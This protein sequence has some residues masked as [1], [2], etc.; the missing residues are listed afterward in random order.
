M[1][2]LQT[3]YI[4][5]GL[6]L[7]LLIY[8]AFQKPDWEET[9]KLAGFTFGG[10][11]LA[12]AVAGYRKLREGFRIRGRLLSFLLFLFLE[13]PFLVYAGT[14]FGL[15]LGAFTLEKTVDEEWLLPGCVGGGVVLGYGLWVLR[16]VQDRRVRLGASVFLAA[17]LGGGALFWFQ[18]QS[19]LSPDERFRFGVLVLLGTPVFYLLTFAGMAEESEVEFG[20]LCA[21]LFVGLWLV[22]ERLTDNPTGNSYIAAAAVAGLL[23]YLYTRYI[24]PGLRV[25]KHTLRGISYARIGQYRLA[26]VSLKRALHHDPNNALARETLW[27]VHREMDLGQVVQDPDTL[28]LVDFD[29]CLSRVGS[30]LLAGPKPEHLQEAHRLL[31]LV[32]GQ[33]PAMEPACDYW[34]AV[35]FC[36]AHEYERAAA[37]LERVLTPTPRNT[38]NKYRKEILMPAWQLALNLHPEMNRRVGTPQLALPQRRM[39]AIGAVERHLAANPDDPDAWNLKRV[40]YADLTE[41]EY[42]EAAGPDEPAKDFD[43]GYAQQLGLALINDPV[44]W[45]RGGEYLRMAA[46]GMPTLGPA[47]F[48]QIAKAH[49]RAG[50]VEGVWQNY[51]LVKLAGRSVGPKNLSAEDRQLYFAVVKLLADDAVSRGDL[52]AAIEDYLLYREYERSGKETYRTLAG[53]Y[54]QK[55]DVWAALHAT[56]QGLVYDG[57]DRDLLER[58]DR[59]YYSVTPDELRE[60]WESVYKYFDVSYC[61]SKAQSLLRLKEITL[62][63]LDWAQHLADLAQAAKPESLAAKVLRAR[64]RLLRG[65]REEAQAMLED[66]RVNRPEKFA[67]AEDEEAWYN[68]CKLLGNMYLQE[69][70]KPDLAVQ[71]FLDFRK[72]PKSGADTMFRLGQAYEELG[73]RVRA[74]KCYGQVVAFEDHPLAPDA[75]DALAR[76]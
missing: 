13:N 52:D 12:M 71:C 4:L 46:R 30:L 32:A 24:L 57:S 33:R 26:L 45:P 56:E 73:D 16:H 27:S 39:E 1:R 58:K 66:V 60:R 29:M 49:E 63:L 54:E 22:L 28:A 20:A 70:H 55:K 21:A 19:G 5:K 61:L 74:K 69:L 68:A 36:H 51:R 50:N 23:Y 40:L 65:E 25:F 34:R 48:I 41:A 47:L 42:D 18:T 15:A 31:D 10:L 38:T 43:H 11:A 3:E 64:T 76:L 35:A 9:A 59:Y 37:A 67:S 8:A 14:L 72:S 53:L 7:G 44:R 6:F 75:R 2:R 17:L 62:D